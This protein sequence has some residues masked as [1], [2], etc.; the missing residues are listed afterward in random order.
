M[1]FA[2]NIEPI[3][4]AA[5]STPLSALVWWLIPLAALV[6]ATF[7]VLWVTRF[8]DKYENQTE[9]SVGKFKKFQDSFKKPE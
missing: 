6:G 2:I 7:Y 1:I 3:A 8:Q 9:R 4:W 5:Q